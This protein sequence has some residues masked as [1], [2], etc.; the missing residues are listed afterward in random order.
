MGKLIEQLTEYSRSKAYP[1]HMPGHKRNIDCK[2][3]PYEFDSPMDL[4]YY[5]KALSEKDSKKLDTYKSTY[6]RSIINA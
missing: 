6:G 2:F 5:L 4:K 1:F 3:N